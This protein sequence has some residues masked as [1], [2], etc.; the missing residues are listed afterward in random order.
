M[1][2]TDEVLDVL[3]NPYRRRLLVALLDENPLGAEDPKLLP[4]VT[5]TDGDDHGLHIK[6]RHVHLPKLA[7]VGYVDWD[8]ESHSVTR[9]PKF[10]EVRPLLELLRDHV[11]VLP[12]DWN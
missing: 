7:D 10:D 2:S 11:D 1:S 3:R 6:I 8:Q 9:G 4:D 12:D 5:M